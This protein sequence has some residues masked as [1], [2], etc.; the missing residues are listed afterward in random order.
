MKTCRTGEHKM[1]RFLDRN[2]RF[3]GTFAKTGSTAVEAPYFDIGPESLETVREN[4]RLKIA[5][6]RAVEKTAAPQRLIDSIRDR[7]RG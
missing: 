7:I 2:C 6:K 1:N 5:L 4:R 3:N